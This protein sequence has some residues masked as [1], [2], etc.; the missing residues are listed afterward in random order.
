VHVGH[1]TYSDTLDTKAGS[2]QVVGPPAYGSSQPHSLAQS[3]TAVIARYYRATH[4]SL[5]RDRATSCYRPSLRHDHLRASQSA[6]VP[7]TQTFHWLR[8]VFKLCNLVRPVPDS[9]RQAQV[10]LSHEQQAAS[11]RYR[12]LQFGKFCLKIMRC[13]YAGAG[14]VPR[15][16]SSRH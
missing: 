16:S 5:T 11:A 10:L 7:S 12:Q 4:A 13:L 2:A 3:L 6:C 9:P 15:L 8:Y 14:L 1:P